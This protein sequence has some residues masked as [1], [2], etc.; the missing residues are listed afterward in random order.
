MKINVINPW[1]WYAVAASQDL[2]PGAVFPILLHGEKLVGWRAGN[3]RVAVWNDRCP[4]RGMSLALGMT[5]GER[6]ICPY[7]GW[8]FGTDGACGRIP[9]HPDLTP[10]RAAR[11]RVY[12]AIEA[13]GYLWACLGEPA[14]GSP[15][16]PILAGL[17]LR[18]VRT[19]H[20]DVEADVL[21]MA[22]LLHPLAVPGGT[23]PAEW[24]VSDGGV[25][26]SHV[27][28]D[29]APAFRTR[30]AF[31]GLVIGDGGPRTVAL[32]QPTG[33]GTAAVHVALAGDQFSAAQALALNRAL[34]RFRR[35]LPSL[36]RGA[37]FAKMWADCMAMPAGQ[38]G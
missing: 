14:V 1:S 32:I 28:D 3:G 16:N 38:E 20:V 18:P 10:S 31:P 27:G 26:V 13:N 34:V 19:L 35:L 36:V 7:H 22:L 21:A 23:R 29:D 37:L 9:A 5:I 11:A 33:E 12:P 2:R 8:E 15:D 4:H 24:E 30:L 25:T 6:L 17:R